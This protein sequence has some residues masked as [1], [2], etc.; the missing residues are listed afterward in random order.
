MMVV[1]VVGYQEAKLRSSSR[2]LSVSSFILMGDSM[3]REERK[4][5]GCEVYYSHE[6][7]LVER[8]LLLVVGCSK[9]DGVREC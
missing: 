3:P 6:F 1:R 5:R 2:K 8:L 4:S 9:I 7:P